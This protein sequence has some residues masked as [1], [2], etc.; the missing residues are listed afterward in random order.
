M[1][2][3]EPTA[4]P[5]ET[6]TDPSQG[7]PPAA[8]PVPAEAT[9]QSPAPTVDWESR[10]KALQPELT[11]Q[12]MA[13][14]AA[15]RALQALR[16]APAPDEDEETPTPARPARRTSESEPEWQKRAL[17]AE[18]QIAQSV[19]GEDVIAAYGTAQELLSRAT[20]PAD[21]VTAFEA[22][23]QARSKGAAPTPALTPE[24]T[25]TPAPVV[26]SNRSD[27]P[28]SAE[29]TQQLR[30]AVEKKDLLGGIKSLLRQG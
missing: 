14:A 11:K 12:Q 4:A 9:P 5:L 2:M 30:E 17:T 19:Y 7:T 6:A 18:W 27:A 15:E 16:S 25:P 8:T 23:H 29:V 22:F 20:T 10:F 26:D 1:A 24:A 28:A 3:T 13:R 21:Y